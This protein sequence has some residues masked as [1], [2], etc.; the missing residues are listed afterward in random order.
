MDLVSLSRGL[1]T[2]WMGH[3]LEV[4]SVI[5]STN[6]RLKDR[7]L[8]FEP[9]AG[10]AVVADSQTEGRGRLGR[11]WWSPPGRGLYTSFAVYPPASQVAGILSL[12]AGVAVAKALT[13]AGPGVAARLKWPNDVVIGGLKCAG[14]LVEGGLAPRPWAVIGIGVNVNGPIAGYLAHAT[15]LSDW[16]GEPVDRSTLW[17]NIAGQL[18][19]YYD[20]WQTQGNAGILR[21][22]TECSATLGRQVVVRSGHETW[23]GLAESV[24]DDGALWL[25]REDGIRQRVASGEVSVRMADGRYAP[26]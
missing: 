1:G 15:S 22:W 8:R 21:A 25:R 2:R 17:Q 19:R 12:L 5:G 14:I 16:V 26:D 13:M 24:D 20:D 9:P 7:L 11:Q 10:A 4:Y 18:E 6:R 23:E 3:D